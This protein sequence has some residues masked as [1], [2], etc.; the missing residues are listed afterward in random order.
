M[1]DTKGIACVYNKNQDSGKTIS[2]R[3]LAERKSLWA[4]GVRKVIMEQMDLAKWGRFWAYLLEKRMLFRELEK[5]NKV[6]WTYLKTEKEKKKDK[7]VM[8]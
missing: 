5:L 7:K 8:E 2:T 3:S 1:R 4:R 6:P